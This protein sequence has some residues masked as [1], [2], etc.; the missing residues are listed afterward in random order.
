MRLVANHEM[1]PDSP[2]GWI[3]EEVDDVEALT[4]TF[5]ADGGT[6]DGRADVREVVEA[7]GPTWIEGEDAWY[8]VDDGGTLFRVTSWCKLS[9]L[10]EWG[11]IEDHL[12]DAEWVGPEGTIPACEVVKSSYDEGP[13]IDAIG[14]IGDDH[15]PGEVS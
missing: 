8:E 3:G 9:E 10:A 14:P 15:R 12:H 7:D 6:L 2:C 11:T 1:S 5:L 4:A 13:S